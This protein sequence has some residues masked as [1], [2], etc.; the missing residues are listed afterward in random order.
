MV[1]VQARNPREA[2]QKML[3]G[4]PGVVMV[5]A[6]SPAEAQA[7]FRKSRGKK[8]LG[9]TPGYLKRLAPCSVARVKTSRYSRCGRCPKNK[10]RKKSQVQE[11][12]L[13]RPKR[14]MSGKS[15]RRLG[16]VPPQI[17]L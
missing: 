8:V 13:A 2:Q 4:G 15:K 5:E 7:I 11:S 16:P 1:M 10:S 17:I 3:G 12:V 9:C 6:G 14:L